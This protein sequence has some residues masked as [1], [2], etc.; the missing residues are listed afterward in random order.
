MKNKKVIDILQTI[1]VILLIVFG[2]FIGY[3]IIRKIFGGSWSTENIIISLLIF[4][5]GFSFTIA[6]SLVRLGSEHN[7]LSNQFRH[8]AND[9][10]VHLQNN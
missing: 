1:V 5:I 4:D 7:Y 3:Q 6:L 10:K 8:L 9:F 2:L